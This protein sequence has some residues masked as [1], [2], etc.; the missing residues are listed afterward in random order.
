MRAADALRAARVQ[1]GR[2][3]RGD[4]PGRPIRSGT[5]T[6]KIA[7]EL[8]DAV[9][10]DLAGATVFA[11]GQAYFAE[12]RV[13]TREATATQVAADV[14]GTVSSRTR[15]WFD[16]DRL[17]GACTCPHAAEGAFCKHMVAAALAWR[18]AL[19]AESAADPPPAGPAAE[20]S[21]SANPSPA[22]AAAGEAPARRSAAEQRREVLRR[23]L[24]A[25]DNQWLAEQLLQAVDNDPVLGKRLLL[26]ARSREAES[27]PRALE[28]AL[29]EAIAQP[30]ALDWRG[31]TRFAQ[32]LDAPIDYLQ[33]LL[34]GGRAQAALAGCLYLLRRLLAI[35]ERADDSGGAI[36]ERVHDLGRLTDRALRAVRP[37]KAIALKM[38]ELAL[39]DRWAVFAD[40]DHG[41]WF[42]AQGLAA[43]EGEIEKRYRALKPLPPG[44]SRFT[45]GDQRFELQ[46]WMETIARRR[47]DVD[48]LVALMLGVED[49]SAHDHL[50]AAEALEEAGRLREATSLLERAVRQFDDDRLLRKLEQ[51]Y[52]RD[53]CSDDA[54]ALLWRRFE[55]RPRRETFAQLR[56]AAGGRWPAWRQRAYA[57][58]AAAEAASL[59]QVQK[60]RRDAAPD[61]GLRLACLAE[62][63]RFDEAAALAE[64]QPLPI[65]TL[66]DAIRL[67]AGPRPET[68][69]NLLRRWLPHAL[70][71]S[72]VSHY[73]RVGE[74]LLDVGRHQP[75]VRF[76]SF[77]AQL[78]AEQARRPRL[79][80]ILDAVAHQLGSAAPQP[81]GGS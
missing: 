64:S 30:G 47:G 59:A 66:A 80:E 13:R 62:E 54:D 11:R 15:L 33:Q 72:G 37:G 32:R 24:V 76:A 70:L 52:R 40:A 31:S 16:D 45:S 26:M 2:R 10:S 51:N 44:R 34:D 27:D 74:M 23:F 1:P 29:L 48:G 3:L 17:Q 55:Q 56:A 42:D 68:A 73:E 35:Y 5:A 8:S 43:F 36:G 69:F 75:A 67:L 60:W 39:A 46:S 41:Q 18:A 6:M 71:G 81:G 58:I 79:V 4:E 7:S 9:V 19:A 65:P 53:G 20:Q 21:P 57:A 25:Q 14:R 63:G 50:R 38:V 12:G 28:R 49:V 22:S 78:R 77:L 61:P